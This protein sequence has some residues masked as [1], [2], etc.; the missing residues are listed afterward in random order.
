LAGQS[1]AVIEQLLLSN[2][3]ASR[4]YVEG[5]AAARATSLESSPALVNLHYMPASEH[6]QT[7]L[8]RQANAAKALAQTTF[9]D[10]PVPGNHFSVM[11]HGAL[12]TRI[13][14]QVSR[15]REK[16]AEHG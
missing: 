5:L 11:Q 3:L 16:D 9:I 8:T 15:L 7:T 2:L 14:D 6:D 13:V 10:E 4:T 1:E 12:A